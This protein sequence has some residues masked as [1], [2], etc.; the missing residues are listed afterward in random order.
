MSLHPHE[1]HAIR[2]LI[3]HLL[4]GL[5]GGFIF[6][7]LIFATD[8]FGLRSLVAGDENGWLATGLLI[9][10]ISVT[11]GSLAMGMGVMALGREK[12]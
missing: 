10:G 3:G 6:A 8:L 4:V 12:S 1:R 7:A 5:A 2:F 11:F 9:F